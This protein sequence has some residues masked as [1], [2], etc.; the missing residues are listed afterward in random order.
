MGLREDFAPHGKFVREKALQYS[1]IMGMAI[2][3]CGAFRLRLMM[4]YQ[5]RL[6]GLRLTALE[7]NGGP[8]FHAL[9]HGLRLPSKKI[10][11]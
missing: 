11:T 9:P 2:V 6:R 7:A 8:L 4:P 10:I 3:L 5:R 1:L